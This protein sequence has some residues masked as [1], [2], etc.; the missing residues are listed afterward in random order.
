MIE[1]ILNQVTE[2]TKKELRRRIENYESPQL[3]P[4]LRQAI[5]MK[6]ASD[7]ALMVRLGCEAVGCSWHNV[8]P[9]MVALEL[10]DLSLIVIDDFF[11]EQTRRMSN[12][13]IFSKFGPLHAVIAGTILKSMSSQALI[14]QCQSHDPRGE[15]ILKLLPILEKAHERI[16]YGQHQDI[17]FEAS[18]I[19]DISDEMYLQM[20]EATT[21]AEISAA[22]QIGAMAGNGRSDVI[23]SLRDFGL[24][25]G[26]IFQLRDDLIDCINNENMIG[27]L[28]FTDI[29]RKRKRL[30]LLM[31]RHRLKCVVRYRNRS[32]RPRPNH[33][34]KI[35]MRRQ[36]TA[37]GFVGCRP[38]TR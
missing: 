14:E 11:D 6:A 13:T 5:D 18:Q 9:A 26:T 21:G 31:A 10:F 28:P 7:R 30:P 15:Q 32:H 33:E 4:L 27:K 37:L 1:D 12:A 36:L 16:Y 23:A 2:V 34:E 29:R 19:A 35:Q 8:T 25:V 3:I 22:V 24:H 17:A 38:P 20:V